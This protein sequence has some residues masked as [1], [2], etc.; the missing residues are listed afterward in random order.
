MDYQTA[1][2]ILKSRDWEIK[3]GP[4]ARRRKNVFEQIAWMRS[5]ASSRTKLPAEFHQVWLA[6]TGELRRLADVHEHALMVDLHVK[7]GKS[8]PQVATALAMEKSRQALTKR[9]K[10][11]NGEFPQDRLP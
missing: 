6:L 8:W 1:E 4:E 10:R 7:R 5:A 2:A 11:L 3:F 9:W